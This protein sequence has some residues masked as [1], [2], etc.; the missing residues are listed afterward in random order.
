MA[1]EY[2]SITKKPLWVWIISKNKRL[3]FLLVMIA[4]ITVFANILP[5]DMQRRIVNE[6]INLSNLDLLVR[7]C[8]IYLASVLA[9]SLLK[10]LI[11]I[12]QNI[13]G[14]RTLQDMRDELYRHV[15]TLPLSF[16]RKTPPGLV[17][18]ALTTELAAA[19]T[20]VGMAIAVPATNLLMLFSFAG[21][22]FWLN[23]LLAALS[24]SV[25]PAMMLV[26][27]VLQKRVNQY[28]KK[29]IDATRKMSSKA[30]ETISGIHEIQANGTYSFEGDKFGRLVNN[31][32][33]IGII[34]NLYRQAVKR[35]SSLFTNF[36]RF[37]VFAAGGYLAI[38]GRLDLGALV[39]FISAQDKLYDPW[40]ELIQF[41]QV[42]QTAQVTYGRTMDYFDIEPEHALAPKD[43][44]PYDLKGN[45]ELENMDFVTGEGVQLLYDIHF[46]LKHGEHMALVGF[47]GSGKSTLAQCIGQLY[48]YTRG[49]ILIDK[50]DVSQLSKADVACSIGFVSQKPFIFE[51]SIEENLLYAFLA[52]SVR[53]QKEVK[54][55]MPSQDDR[56]LM[57]QQ[58]GLFIDVLRF[59]L[60]T[61]LE[62]AKYG[63][64]VDQILQVREAFQLEYGDELA[65]I[66]EFYDPDR[67]L[68]RS[69]VAENL[70]FGEA[71]KDS[72]R[73]DKLPQNKRFI[74]FLEDAGL[75]EPLLHLG[76]QLIEASIQ[77]Y[78]SRSSK[79]ER[80]DIALI[81]P[82]EIDEYKS[83]LYHLKRKS[84][85]NIK[86]NSRRK[87]LLA[88]LK[89]IPNKYRLV[90][91]PG[92]LSNQIIEGRRLFRE[93]VY[94]VSPDEISSC[95]LSVYLY[96]QTIL[97]NILFGKPKDDTSVVWDRINTSINQL[98]IEKAFLE[99][100]IEMGM[101]YQVG[102]KGGNLSGG[103]QQKLAIARVLLKKPPIL[104][105]DEATSGLDNE[106][107]AH[108]QHLLEDRWKGTSTLIAV[109][110]RLDIIKEYDTVAVMKDG[111]I[112]EMGAYD[113]LMD[114]RGV[115]F[116]LVSQKNRT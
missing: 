99:D 54:P 68:Y 107:Q 25:S 42:Y 9:A 95:Q 19:G 47:S 64:I 116:E 51:G 71:L 102:S 66:V 52:R 67:Y 75:T 62:E 111:R 34:W 79:E 114:K 115:L 89:F 101:Q 86:K 59:G 24:L 69:S 109:V 27:P 84:A 108:I 7:Y 40:K 65:D 29:R 63:D 33:K 21:Y 20:F 36:G 16:Y 49:K 31:Q 106:S 56:I 17:I 11:N 91:L 82:D 30:G 110:H 103:Q 28:N 50:K 4:A 93:K 80:L 60:D 74:E 10:Y 46:N 88:A 73:V 113:D 18:S 48:K 96:S 81:P 100:I 5:L 85:G 14:Q 15:L 8:G 98:L 44:K 58:T 87:I 57:L 112:L 92:Q 32:R 55:E 104:I 6:A 3:Q 61:V 77:H 22:L 72:F 41:Y 1:K 13:I 97:T 94:T 43:R 12:L 76:T 90:E 70:M 2:S 37:L 45:I 26:V 53:T 35:V 78:G 23:P 83:I 38:R 105:M 39:A